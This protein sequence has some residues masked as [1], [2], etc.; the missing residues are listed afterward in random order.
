M[1]GAERAEL[2]TM[3]PNDER[4]TGAGALKSVSAFREISVRN[5]A[6]ERRLEA[7]GSAERGGEK[8]TGCEI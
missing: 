8:V 4:Q 5:N 1:S 2:K 7:Q 3:G 6:S